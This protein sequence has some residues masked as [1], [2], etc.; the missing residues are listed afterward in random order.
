MVALHRPA[1]LEVVLQLVASGLAALA[2]VPGFAPVARGPAGGE[3]YKGAYPG[4]AAPRPLRAGY[5]YLPPGYKTTERYPVIYL[6][7]GLP[8]SPSEYIYSLELAKQARSGQSGE[9]C[10]SCRA[11]C[12]SA[13]SASRS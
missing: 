8:G 5:L 2:L 11:R 4:T 6:L 9:R 13:A 12:R 7:H 3:I 1:T 10:S